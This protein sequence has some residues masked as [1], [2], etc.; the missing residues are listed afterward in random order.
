MTERIQQKDPA[1]RTKMK[2]TETGMTPECSSVERDYSYSVCYVL[3]EKDGKRQYYNQMVISI[4][5]L[6]YRAFT[7]RVYVVT[8][9]RT[10][11][12]LTE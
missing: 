3:T 8:D 12:R 10:A 6:R 9:D 7:G 2:C 4:A 11:C 1:D 5:S